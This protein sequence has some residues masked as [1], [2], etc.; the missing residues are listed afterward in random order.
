MLLKTQPRPNHTE[1]KGDMESDGMST[2]LWQPYW[3]YDPPIGV[4]QARQEHQFGDSLL[5]YYVHGL[6]PASLQLWP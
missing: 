6:D 4:H 2:L 3:F 5:L 1:P